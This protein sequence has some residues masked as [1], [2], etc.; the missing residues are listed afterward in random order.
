[1]LQLPPVRLAGAGDDSLI[2]F[3][4]LSRKLNA[5]WSRWSKDYLTSLRDIVGGHHR[6][7]RLQELVLVSD[8]VRSRGEWPLALVVDVFPGDDGVVRVVNVR[9][10]KDHTV[11][12]MRWG[13]L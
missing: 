1:M 4:W 10:L 11:H 13:P 7:P 2:N 12:Q 8:D 6:Q 9:L 5:F 3:N